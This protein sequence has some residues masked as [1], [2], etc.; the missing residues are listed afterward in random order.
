MSWLPRCPAAALLAGLLATLIVVAQPSPPPAR[1]NPLCDVGSAPAGVVT[2]GVGAITGGIIGG[3]NPV[4]DACNAVSGEVTGAVTAPITDALKG[5]SNGIFQQI[6]T[7]VA[8]GASWLIGQ[9]V[10]GIEETTTPQLTTRGFLA[11]YG[12]MAEIA[13][14]MGLA[15]LL[16]A[17]LEGLAQGNAGLLARVVLINLPLAFIATSVA[18]AVVQLLLVATDG[19]CHAIATASHDNS[20]HFF[21]AA[22]TGLGEAGGEVGKEVDG[23]ATGEPAGAAVG[24]AAGTVEVPL[25]V[26]FLAAII[27]AFAAFLVWLELLMRDAAI[28]VVALFMP[29]ALAASIWPRWMGALR[30]SGELLVVVI[31]SKFVIVSI[32]SLAAGLVAESG[33]NVEHILA[34]SALMLLACFAPFVLL[35]LVPFAEGAMG[36]AYGRRS[37][38]GGAVSG[39]QIA[40]DVQILRNMARSNWGESGATLWNS[41]EQGGGSPG[42]EPSGPGGGAGPG[43]GAGGG[44]GEA[45]G[46]GGGEAA[47]GGA[48]A[49]AGAAAAVPAAAIAGT[50]AAAQRLQ[51]T[52]VAQQAGSSTGAGAAPV[53]ELAETG[54][55]APRREAEGGGAPGGDEKPPRP[56]PEP[57]SAK[58]EKGTKS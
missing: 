20:Q 3:G 38:A 32:I 16:L 42:P 27:G 1:A 54:G 49:G 12:R 51:G 5:V 40:S 41:G 56:A 4:G 28:Y 48:A 58:P 50:K 17:V 44:G 11:Q 34:A 9:V 23:G 2:E 33:S 37:A 57:P 52:G 8:D 31:G 53:E 19:M 21:K 45:G 29:M 46:A 35:K 47:A 30:R 13:A 36:A 26:T 22:I 10:K 43:A 39:V 7:W 18:Y 25:F 14:L 55:G 6:T 15:M 24:Q